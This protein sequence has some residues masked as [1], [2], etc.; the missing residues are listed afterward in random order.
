[1]LKKSLHVFVI[2]SKMKYALLFMQQSSI[3]PKTK[4][5][6]WNTEKF[7]SLVIKSSLHL[8]T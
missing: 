5:S 2:F 3:F 4:I 8:T 6:R 7:I 1:M